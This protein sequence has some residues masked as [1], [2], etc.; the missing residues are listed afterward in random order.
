MQ[1]TALPPP[2]TPIAGPPPMGRVTEA[3][4]NGKPQPR[5]LD[6]FCGEG[7]AGHGYALAGFE[8]TGVDIREQRRYPHRFIRADA[9]DYLN[10]HYQEYDVIHAS[11][12]CRAHSPLRYL[13]SYRYHDFIPE[14]RRLLQA[15]GKPYIIENVETAPL[16]RPVLLCGTMFGMRTYRHRLFETNIPMTR[17]KH[18]VHKWKVAPAGREPY[19]WEFAT[20]AGNFNGVETARKVMQMPWATR[21]GIAE[22]IPPPYTK[23]LGEQALIALRILGYF[24]DIKHQSA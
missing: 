17:P 2:V 15:S 24:D 12:P 1:Q 20:Y 9:L 21:D 5:L 23:Y 18:P 13:H 4:P 14:T 8:V 3:Q 22:A 7:G 16:Q 10:E 6:L 19:D 11:P